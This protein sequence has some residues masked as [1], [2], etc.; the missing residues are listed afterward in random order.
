MKKLLYS[1]AVAA[2]V[3]VASCAR[4]IAPVAVSESDFANVNIALSLGQATKAGDGAQATALQMGVYDITADAP[5]FMQDLSL[6][7]DNAETLEGGKAT[8]SLRLVK[9]QAYRFVFWAQDP[10]SDAYTATITANGATVAVNPAGTIN[11]EARDAFAACIE[12]N[13]PVSEDSQLSATLKRVVAQVNVIATDLAVPAD[14]G[15]S[16]AE[17]AGVAFTQSNLVVKGMPTSLDLISGE[18]SGSADYTFAAAASDLLPTIASGY[19]LAGEEQLATV[20]FTAEGAVNDAA[21]R[22]AYTGDKAIAN[23]PVQKNYRT[24]ISGNIFT[25]E[26][27]INVTVDANWNTPDYEKDIEVV[28]DVTATN[29]A[30]VEDKESSDPLSYVIETVKTDNTTIVIPAGMSSK[31]LTFTVAGF[32]TG[33]AAAPALTIQDEGATAAY[34]GDVTIVLPAG[35]DLGVVTVN[36]PAAHVT[37]TNGSA[38]Q[39]ISTTGNGTLVIAKDFSAKV[40]EVLKGNVELAGSVETIVRGEGNADEVTYVTLVEGYNWKNQATDTAEGTKVVIK[41]EEEETSGDPQPADSYFVKA[42]TVSAGQY[43]IVYEGEEGAVAFNGGLETLDAV[44]NTI[45]VSIDG[46]KIAASEEAQ[47][48]SFTIAAVDGGYTIQAATG[49]YIGQTTFGNGLKALDEPAVNTIAIEDDGTA[50]ISVVL[51]DGTV[52]LKYNKAA[53]QTRFRYYKSGQESIA[54]YKLEGEGTPTETSQDPVVL[55]DIVA[56]AG[57]KAVSVKVG[58]SSEKVE[59]TVTDPAEGATVVLAS[60]DETVAT[61]AEGIVTGVAVGETEITATITAEGYNEKVISI[62]VSVAEATQPADNGD[63]TL[64]NPFN[65][66]GVID[67]IDNA[68]SDKVYVKGIISEI[69]NEYTSSSNATFY[70]AEGD[71]KFEAYRISFLEDKAWIYNSENDHNTQIK[72]GDEVIIYGT[73]ILYNKTV[74]E[75]SSAYLYSLNG[76]TKEDVVAKAEVAK[77]DG[78]LANPFNPAG[79]KAYIDAGNSAAVYVA[80]IISS[81]ANNGHFAGNSYG[82]ATF[83]ISEDGTA[84]GT[85]FEAYQ[86]NYLNNVKYED[87]NTD[88]K[89]GDAVVIYGPVTYYEKYNVYETQGKGAAYLYSLN[90]VVSKTAQ[91]LSFDPTS[92]TINLGDQFTAPVLSGAQTTVTYSSTNTNVA[93]VDETTGSVTILAI[94]TTTINATAAETDE[95]KAGTASYTITVKDPNASQ[96]GEPKIVT[97]DFSAQG[98]ANQQEVTSISLDG[99]TVTFDKGT[100]SNAPKYYNSGAAVRVYGGGYFTVSAGSNISSINV[101]FA[102]GEGSN[103]ITTDVGSYD[104]GAWTGSAESVTF[105]VGGTSGHRRI[106]SIEVTLAE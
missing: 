84:A 69:V 40:I 75:T 92:V 28:T 73:V 6:L 34:A 105:T 64:E 58:E 65:V 35:L 30:L 22:W 82:Q 9:G 43:L 16:A 104:N 19:V 26:A 2:L 42:T 102:S 79:V 13:G 62:P 56:E 50:T 93:T 96:T 67:Y 80:G 91:T 55:K 95:Y 71:L 85:Q 59:V 8:I 7:G 45:A 41:K 27:T 74:Y 77:G 60:K 90:G 106:T 32:E 86:I 23:V 94:G 47:H 66:A 21:K 49:K 44:S 15:K 38:T 3:L 54:L 51:T 57:V 39:V 29:A 61:I 88:V 98:Y 25:A 10:A 83:Y 101:G 48:A 76:V 97:I 1:V 12:T 81:F 4:E 103:V 46:D 87:G 100:N 99:V 68:G 14:G 37:L 63:G 17:K 52:T 5:V 31:D 11:D 53:N 24:N 36:L 20:E 18:V 72:V 78:S 70:I 33:E 89:E